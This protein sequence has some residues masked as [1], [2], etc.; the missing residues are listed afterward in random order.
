MSLDKRLKL[1]LSSPHL[2]VNME[3]N[4]LPASV[5]CA[6]QCVEQVAEKLLRVLLCRSA[7]HAILAAQCHFQFRRIYASSTSLPHLLDEFAEFRPDF[8]VFRRR[9]WAFVDSCGERRRWT[10]ELWQIVGLTQALQDGVHEACVADVPQAALPLDRRRCLSVVEWIARRWLRWRNVRRTIT[11]SS[12]TRSTQ[13][14]SRL[15]LVAR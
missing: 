7:V 3:W 8:L 1:L 15:A 12:I 10:D 14:V 6:V 9:R 5:T 13:T 11:A 2:I 4:L